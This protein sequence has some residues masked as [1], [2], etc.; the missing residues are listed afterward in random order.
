MFSASDDYLVL[1]SER[2]HQ[3]VRVPCSEVKPAADGF[4][5]SIFFPASNGQKGQKGQKGLP[6]SLPTPP[7]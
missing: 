2:T 7:F 5:P 6:Y 4:V 3:H 1:G